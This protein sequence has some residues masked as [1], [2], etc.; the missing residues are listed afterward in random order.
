MHLADDDIQY[1]SH[2]WVDACVYY[3]RFRVRVLA[4]QEALV[5]G[6]GCPL[7]PLNDTYINPKP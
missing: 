6:F 5:S 3:L 2:H 1:N 7:G 4:V